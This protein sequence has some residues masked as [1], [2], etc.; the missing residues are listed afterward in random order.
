MID[1]NVLEVVYAHLKPETNFRIVLAVHGD[2][3][4]ARVRLGDD[5]SP[6]FR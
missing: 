5:G 3:L 6:F 4:A 1:A 2:L